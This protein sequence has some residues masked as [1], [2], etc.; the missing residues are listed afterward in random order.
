MRIS[1]TERKVET[2]L[3]SNDI[4]LKLSYSLPSGDSLTAGWLPAAS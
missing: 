4:W 3:A 2:D 1:P